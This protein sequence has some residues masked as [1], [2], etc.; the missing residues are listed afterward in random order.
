MRR[1][2][3]LIT[4]GV[5][6]LT[7]SAVVAVRFMR[8][9][10]TVASADGRPPAVQPSGDGAGDPL[11]DRPASPGPGADFSGD[12]AQQQ[13]FQ[14]A[15]ALIPKAKG[16]LAVVVRDRKTGAE[17]RGGEVTYA[18]W[19]SSTIKLAMATN[20][21]E[22]ARTGEIKLDTPARK[23][24]ADML[25]TSSDKAANALWDKYGADGF[26]PWFQQQYGMTNLQYPA[27]V[28]RRWGSLKCTPDD[29]LHLMTYVLDRSDPA[30][31][32]YLMAAMRRPGTVQQWGVW[33][34]AADKQP[35]LANGW[36]L[37]TD[38]KVKHW[39][40]HSVGFA[41]PDAQYVV[42]VMF[43]QPAGA[44]IDTGVHTVSDLVATIF[45][46]KTPAA[47]TVPPSV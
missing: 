27:G 9:Y 24:I 42:V 19:A 3:L 38:D 22:R 15:A 25:D 17:W 34:A 39:V 33:A 32:D 13:R 20:L 36:S 12:P 8:T 10:E 11:T 45:G 4:A 2:P 41:G 37:E 23:N 35:G 29:L 28:P 30:D 16:H 26:V 40:T 5:L 47:V 44:K 7:V 14:T 46:A 43:D 21:L 18:T 6:V 31:R 1:S